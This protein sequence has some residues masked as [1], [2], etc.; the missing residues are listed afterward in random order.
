M[1][2][3]RLCS[4][5]KHSGLRHLSMS[6]AADRKF[7]RVYSYPTTHKAEKSLVDSVAELVTMR[8]SVSLSSPVASGSV[9][10]VSS[11]WRSLLPF[12]IDDIRREYVASGNPV[13]L[14]L[15]T[16][17]VTVKRSRSWHF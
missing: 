7:S 8:P 2:Q 16:D 4:L 15:S 1:V 12:V 14:Q 5:L 17:Q 9:P 10:G 11:R 3:G 6:H 13:S